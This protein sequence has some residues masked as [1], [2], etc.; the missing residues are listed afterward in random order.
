MG[1]RITKEKVDHGDGKIW[2]IMATWDN[3]RGGT[4]SAV[5]FCKTLAAQRRIVYGFK[6][7]W[8][9]GEYD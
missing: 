5:K 4:S 2:R 7:K 9:M 3:S 8:R 1:I 6:M